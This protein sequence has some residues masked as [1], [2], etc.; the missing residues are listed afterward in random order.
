MLT[1]SVTL[2]HVPLTQ[3]HPFPVSFLHWTG[4]D[5]IRCT[6]IKDHSGFWG[7]TGSKGSQS[8]KG[9]AARVDVQAGGPQASSSVTPSLSHF[10]CE[11]GEIMAS[12]TYGHFRINDMWKQL[13]TLLSIY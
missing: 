4:S 12:A 1:Q 5:I 6:L 11:T 8:G 13:S 7:E 3:S 10:I 2:G 9:Q